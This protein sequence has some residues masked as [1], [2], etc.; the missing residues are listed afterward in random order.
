MFID[1]LEQIRVHFAAGAQRYMRSKVPRGPELVA[2][3][4]GCLRLRQIV[5]ARP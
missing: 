4:S 1:A 5:P 3:M 2:T